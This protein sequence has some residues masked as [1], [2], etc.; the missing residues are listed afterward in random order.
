LQA[1]ELVA[2]A[3]AERPGPSWLPA[4]SLSQILVYYERDGTKVAVVHQYLRPDGALGASG[5]P[6]PKL[7]VDEGTVYLLDRKNT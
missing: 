1:G 3:E 2:L 4:G 7:I 6:D 5:M